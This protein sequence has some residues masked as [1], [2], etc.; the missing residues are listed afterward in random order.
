MEINEL[1]FE[2]HPNGIGKRAKHKFKNGYMA[3]VITGDVYFTSPD[4]PYEIAV[5]DKDENIT[6]D[7]PITGDVLGYLNEEE[8][9]KVLADIEALES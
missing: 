2:Q 6:Y 8:A 4:K 7:T 1:I 9:N 3:S 5:M